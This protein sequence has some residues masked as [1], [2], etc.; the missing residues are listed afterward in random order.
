MK[1]LIYL[2]K[3]SLI[4]ITPEDS[5]IRH[6]LKYVYMYFPRSFRESYL[7]EKT[8][9]KLATR[10]DIKFIQIGTN[11]GI[12]VDPL[13]K[14][15]KKNEWVGLMIEPNPTVFDKLR[16]NHKKSKSKIIF[17]KVA[18]G[19]IGQFTLYWCPEDTGMASTNKEHVTKFLN[20]RNFEILEE[21][22]NMITF[23]NLINKYPE[24]KSVNILL[25]DTEGWDAKI[26]GS[27]D[28][29]EFKS[30]VIIFE[31]AHLD[32]DSY[33]SVI[34]HLVSAEYFCSTS[35]GDTI[36]IYK[37]TNLTEL[38]SILNKTYYL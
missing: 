31:S 4:K 19:D 18:I 17:E 11:D 26:I 9:K 38:K 29:N 35:R 8:I 20:N 16:N 24:Y 5:K 6:I 27:I 15:V 36:A 10:N 34:D 12:H 13:Y 28:F 32:N 33:T 23:S 1:C 22:I 25:T 3:N 30:D 37:N 14:Y 2:L 7:L 21:K